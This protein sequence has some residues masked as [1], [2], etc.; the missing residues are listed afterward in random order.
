MSDSNSDPDDVSAMPSNNNSKK[1]TLGNSSNN[2]LGSGS[3]IRSGQRDHPRNK[4]RTTTGY[5]AR[6]RRQITGMGTN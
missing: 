6:P 2:T 5:M 1:T 3:E 4:I